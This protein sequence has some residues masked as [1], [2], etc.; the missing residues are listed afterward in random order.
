MC[1]NDEDC[2][3]GATCQTETGACDCGN[4]THYGTLYEKTF[5]CTVDG[6]MNSN[7]ENGIC[8]WPA[9]Y[10]DQD[11]SSVPDCVADADCG[12]QPGTCNNV[13]GSCVC[14][15]GCFYGKLCQIKP[16]C[17]H[18]DFGCFNGGSCNA[19]GELFSAANCG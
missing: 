19:Q 14:W 7:E 13:T 18:T 17:R 3:S 5:D 15:Y 6:C 4:T 16:N 2:A 1:S 11:C 9:P 10:E 8:E 12:L